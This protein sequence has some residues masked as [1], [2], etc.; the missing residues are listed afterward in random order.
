M[1]TIDPTGEGPAGVGVFVAC[2]GLETWFLLDTYLDLK[3]LDKRDAEI[4]E[5]LEKMN[6]C[7]EKRDVE[8]H[9][10]I[11]KLRKEQLANIQK[12]LP[13]QIALGIVGVV[14]SLACAAALAL[15]PES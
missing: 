12:K 15:F 10:E 4:V 7:E 13:K 3:D 5:E 14:G 6:A 8:K 1:N 9:I 11:D 2:L